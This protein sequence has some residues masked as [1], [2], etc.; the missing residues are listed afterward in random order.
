MQ[1][2]FENE[3]ASKLQPTTLPE[4]LCVI[5]LLLG[6]GKKLVKFLDFL[7]S[8]SEINRR[9]SA[10]FKLKLLKEGTE[11]RD[12]DSAFATAPATGKLLLCYCLASII[13]SIPV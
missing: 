2:T 9:N 1:P 5:S 4:E 8:D 13:E 7:A 3:A 11:M 12:I 6:D 10:Y